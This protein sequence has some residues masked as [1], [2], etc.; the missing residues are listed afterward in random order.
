MIQL[1]VIKGFYKREKALP[2]A[3]PMRILVIKEAEGYLHMNSGDH[4]LIAGRIFFIPEEGLVRLDGEI[5]FAYW[6]TFSSILYAEFLLQHLDPLAKNLFLKLSYRD[7]DGNEFKKTTSLIEQ[8]RKEVDA[9]RDVAYL[10]QYLSLFLGYTSDLD[11]YLAALS[12]D[13]LQQ[14]LRFRAILEQFYKTERSIEFY[15]Q[16][17]GISSRKLNLFL[18]KVL[19]KSLSSLIK[20]R[21]MREAEMLLLHSDYSVDEIAKIL[22]FEQTSNF[23]STFRRYKGVTVN[24]FSH[25][26]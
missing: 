16:G 13:E 24:Q 6:L 23:H 3:F 21:I 17:M 8:L 7:L 1:E 12:L 15:A 19:G 20:D 26:G 2:A 11:G 5:Q 18:S 10:S 25:L 14:V 4:K 9:R 22:G